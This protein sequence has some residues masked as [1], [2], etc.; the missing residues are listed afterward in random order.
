LCLKGFCDKALIKPKSPKVCTDGGGDA[1]KRRVSG[2]STKRSWC[3]KSFGGGR[4]AKTYVKRRQ[5]KKRSHEITRTRTPKTR[6]VQPRASGGGK[7]AMRP[8]H[9]DSLKGNI[10]NNWCS[11]CESSKKEGGNYRSALETRQPKNHKKKQ[12]SA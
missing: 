12:I 1:E 4:I 5:K 11:R 8:L 9:D 7:Q 10:E 6:K 3:L 2:K